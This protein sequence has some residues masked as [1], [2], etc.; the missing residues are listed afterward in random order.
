MAHFAIEAAHAESDEMREL[1]EDT[2]G[3]EAPQI[4]VQENEAIIVGRFGARSRVAEGEA[5][6][7]VVD[8]RALHFFD[9]A[10]GNGIYGSTK[11]DL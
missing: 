5:V 8:T 3:G 11:G 6:T 4:G 1:A 9:P 7:A 2:G 10:T